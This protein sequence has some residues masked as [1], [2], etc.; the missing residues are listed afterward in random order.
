[1]ICFD[2][3][4]TVVILAPQD[5]GRKKANLRGLSRRRRRREI[6]C[7]EG[8]PLLHRGGVWDMLPRQKIFK[9]F[10]LK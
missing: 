3:I 1:M 10:I 6:G 9:I 2:I 5:P 8:C 7:E 4:S